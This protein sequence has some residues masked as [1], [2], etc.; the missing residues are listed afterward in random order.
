MHTAKQSQQQA[1]HV[2]NRNKINSHNLIELYS[3]LHPQLSSEPLP[4][5]IYMFW[6]HQPVRRNGAMAE[7]GFKAADLRSPDA[8]H[9]AGSNPA[10]TTLFHGT[11]A[12]SGFKAGDSRSSHHQMAQVRILPVSFF[13][14]L[15]P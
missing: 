13:Y 2:S 5:E 15:I 8:L 14:R 11:V 6:K 10:G 4:C 3:N 12:E 1:P 9:R 7:S